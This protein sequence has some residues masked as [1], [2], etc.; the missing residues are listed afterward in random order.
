MEMLVIDRLGSHTL[1]RRAFRKAPPESG[2]ASAEQLRAL[3]AYERMRA[4]RSDSS[5]VLLIFRLPSENVGQDG[6]VVARIL[7]RRLRLTDEIGW[8]EDGALAALLPDTS[9]AGGRRVA[10]DVLRLVGGRVRMTWDLYTYPSNWPP[11]PYDDESD[12]RQDGE[13]AKPARPLEVLFVQPL[14]WW[15]RLIDVVAAGAALVLLAPRLLVVAAAV[16]LTSP[17][18]LFFRQQRDGYGG[19]RFWMVKFRTMYVDAEERKAA[20]RHLSEQDGPAFKL[21]NDPRVTWLGRYLRRTCI[22]ELPQLWHVL[23]GQMSLVGP[24]PLDSN[25]AKSCAPWQRRRHDVTPGLTCIWQVYGKSQVPFNEWMR[26]DLRYVRTRSLW[27]D[28]KLI[29]ATMVAVILHRG[30]Q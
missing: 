12:P 3:V 2:L 18:P 5:F 30:S 6:A 29:F 24:R 10:A 14:P 26:M 1:A 23:R 11:A 9:A 13:V 27:Q 7:D 22:D 8:W 21:K 4:E 28:L 17:G 19:R 25:E 15:K 16:K 20:L